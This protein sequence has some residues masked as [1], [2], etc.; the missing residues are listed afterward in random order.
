MVSKVP[1][2]EQQKD[3]T[4]GPA[5]LRMVFKFFNV[6]RSEAQLKRRLKTTAR[7]GTDHRAM[8]RTAER[9]G[10][11]CYVNTYSSLAE[12]KY[13]LHTGHP[14]IVNYIEPSDNE[15]HYAVVTGYSHNHLI[16][17]DPLN[18]R[19]FKIH[20]RTFSRRWRS[21]DGKKVRWIM[22]ISKK[23]F[24]LGKQYYPLK[25]RLAL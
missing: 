17:N 18:G 20:N 22:V 5:A 4:C 19:N 8:I 3:Y 7:G 21:G 11:Y 24:T 9:E 12:V 6:R 23:P 16:L 14:V 15:G 13:Y 10:F 2:F 1:Y 25:K